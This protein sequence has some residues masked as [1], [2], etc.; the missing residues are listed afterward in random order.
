MLNVSAVL[1]ES[2]SYLQKDMSQGVAGVRTVTPFFI[3]FMPYFE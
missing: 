3:D 1:H 2:T